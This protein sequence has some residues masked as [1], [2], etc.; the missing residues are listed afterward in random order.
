MP[1]PHDFAFFAAATLAIKLMD[2]VSSLDEGQAIG[3]AWHAYKDKEAPVVDAKFRAE[4][5][6][7][8]VRRAILDIRGGRQGRVETPLDIWLKA[9]EQV[10]R[11]GKPE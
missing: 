5:Y 4:R 7:D 2:E 3:I 11:L 10:K 1:A 6:D 9:L 8:E